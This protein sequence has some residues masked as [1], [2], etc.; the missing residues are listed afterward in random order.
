[1]G[2]RGVPAGRRGLLVPSCVAGPGYMGLEVF[3]ALLRSHCLSTFCIQASLLL[4]RLD[5]YSGGG[6]HM[7]GRIL[8]ARSRTMVDSVVDD[9]QE[10]GG[11]GS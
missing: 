7:G 4:G 2:C 6:E 10:A 5:G 11:G 8:W 3:F 9:K 1:M